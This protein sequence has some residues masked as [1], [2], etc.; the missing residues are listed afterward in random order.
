MSEWGYITEGAAE[1]RIEHDP[2]K[3][4]ALITALSSFV[5]EQ[6]KEIKGL[7]RKIS[8]QKQEIIAKLAVI[9]RL[10]Q[11]VGRLEGYI[12]CV[13]E[14]NG[15]GRVLSEKRMN[16]ACPDPRDVWKD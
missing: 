8:E 1:R 2:K 16:Q 4:A 15:T 9:S 10:N 5:L 7:D 6:E 12:E 14:M 13:R 11:Q 3:A